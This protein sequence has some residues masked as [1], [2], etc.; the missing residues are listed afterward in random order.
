M[1]ITVSQT[2]TEYDY[3]W[4]KAQV[5]AW[6]HRSDLTDQIPDFIALAEDEINS[7]L[8]LRMMEQ[9]ADLTLAS[10]E[11]TVD[12]PELYMEP[13]KLELVISGR[14]N[15]GLVFLPSI[16][17]NEAYSC[18]PDYWA[19]D[20][21]QIAFPHPANLSYSLSFRYMQRLDIANTTTNDLLTNYRGLY[22]YGSLVQASAFIQNDARVPQWVSMY[23]SLKAKVQRREGRNRSLANLR[24]DLP[25]NTPTFNIYKG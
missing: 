4:L 6:L 25:N 24:T 23:E 20:G 11:R 17:A 19:V 7:E 3:D 18:E 10:G 16:T 14:E 5:A 12:L 15:K 21:D 1:A 13:L 9:T 8:R 2:A 22:L